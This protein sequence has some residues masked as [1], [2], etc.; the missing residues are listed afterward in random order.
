MEWPLILVCC[1][2]FGSREHAVPSFDLR[3][4]QSRQGTSTDGTLYYAPVQTMP[5]SRSHFSELVGALDVVI[6]ND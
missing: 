6:A 5:F 4:L 1:T 2:E 3:A